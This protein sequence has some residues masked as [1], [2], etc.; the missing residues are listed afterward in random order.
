MVFDRI[1]GTY[2]DVMYMLMTSKLIFLMIILISLLGKT[3]WMYWDAI[4]FAICIVNCKIDPENVNVDF[5]K[6]LINATSQQFP[7]ARIVCC[8]FHFN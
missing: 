7:N 2:I 3:T 8:L 4:H 1:T 5:E 6:S